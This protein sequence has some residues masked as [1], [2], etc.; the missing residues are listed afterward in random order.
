MKDYPLLKGRMSDWKSPGMFALVSILLFVADAFYF[1]WPLIPFLIAV[2]CC[3]GLAILVA[4]RKRL[5]TALCTP[6]ALLVVS[7]LGLALAS[8]VHT[9]D[10]NRYFADYAVYVFAFLV[11]LLPEGAEGRETGVRRIRNVLLLV[12]DVFILL[13]MAL[14]FLRKLPFFPHLPA[15][16]QLVAENTIEDSVRYNGFFSNGITSGIF[17]MLA[18]ILSIYYLLDH[19]SRRLSWLAIAAFPFLMYAFAISLCRTALV[20]GA[21]WFFAFLVLTFTYGAGGGE[22]FRM[23][24]RVC[25]AFIVVSVLL[26]AFSLASGALVHFARLGDIKGGNGR[27]LIYAAAIKIIESHPW[28]GVGN[29]AL[30]GLLVALSNNPA[31]D[32]GTYAS[33]G[34]HNVGLDIAALYGIPAGVL[35][36]VFASVPVIRHLAF[37]RKADFRTLFF[38]MHAIPLYAFLLVCFLVEARGPFRAK[39]EGVLFVYL[40]IALVKERRKEAR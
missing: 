36:L 33:G 32:Y 27:D 39:A 2:V 8:F 21:V 19:P 30:P 14:F 35:F 28:L 6:L 11:F 7:F 26:T 38:R 10:F 18:M 40:A 34:C 5:K 16:I 29:N 31:A 24:K 37:W 25:I 13:S 15:V 17:A 12:L 1:F 23:H 9:R 3:Y 4:E 22:S 20:M